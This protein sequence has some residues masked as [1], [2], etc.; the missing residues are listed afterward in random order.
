MKKLFTI[1]GIITSTLCLA[2]EPKTGNPK[3]NLMIYGEGFM[4]SLKEPSGWTVDV[5][6][7]AKYNA[8]VIF[9]AN[10]ND[11]DK[12]GALVQ[13]QAFSKNDENTIE[14]LKYDIASYKRDYP[15]LKEQNLEAKH[16]NY[17][18]FSKL[19]YVDNKFFQ[20]ITYINPGTKYHNGISVAMNISKRQATDKELL[21]YRQIINSLIMIK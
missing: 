6:N 4:F 1:L 20:Y 15:T 8:N 3:D 11:M 19:I 21:A 16:K 18:T 9:Y 2:Q 5:D 12:G 7:A 13:A 17:K 14:D 10:K